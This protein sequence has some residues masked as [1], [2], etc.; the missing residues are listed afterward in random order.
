MPKS[1]TSETAAQQAERFRAAA[2]EQINAGELSSTDEGL[3]RIMRG[4]ARLRQG[5]FDGEEDQEYSS[6]KPDP[7]ND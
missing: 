5:W 6:S 2:Q 7:P 1:K 4:V 3:E